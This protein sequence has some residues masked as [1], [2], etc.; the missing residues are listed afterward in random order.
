MKY[1]V[2][3]WGF[4]DSGKSS[5]LDYYLKGKED[6]KISEIGE[7]HSLVET[8]SAIFSVVDLTKQSYNFAHTK[9]HE[10]LRE[11]QAIIYVID[12]VSRDEISSSARVFWWMFEWAHECEAILLFD[13]KSDLDHKFADEVESGFDLDRFDSL[14]IEFKLLS[15]SSISGDGINE[16]FAWL[17]EKLAF[18]FSE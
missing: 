6:V 13:N 14:N 8:D 7:E 4:E 1:K 11:S 15:S 5:L 2:S 3:V 17:F 10:F 16:G 12:P 9:W 18:Y